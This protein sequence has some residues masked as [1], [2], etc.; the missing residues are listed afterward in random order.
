MAVFIVTYNPTRWRWDDRQ[1]WE[2]RTASGRTIKGRWS[3]GSRT[4]GITPEQDRVFLLRQGPGPRGIMGSGTFLSAAYTDEHWDEDRPGDLANYADILWES[5]L[6]DDDLLPLAE[7]EAQ[8]PGLPWRQGVRGSGAMVPPP[9][10]AELE[11]LWARHT[12]GG[13]QPGGNGGG[14]RKRGSRQAWQDDPV[15]R[16]AVEDY[17]QSLLEQDY[18]D[19]GWSVEDTR[20]G[21]PFDAMAT[22]G[23]QVRYL[24]AKGTETDGR[25]VLV[26]KAEVE[27]ARKHP[28]ECVL[29]IVSDIRFRSDASLDETSGRLVVTPWE[30]DTG[31]LTATG[32]SWAPPASP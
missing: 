1:K 3:I 13:P 29:G 30:P 17:A 5:V 14:A 31:T 32:Y 24:E 2:R 16:K 20:R 4:R 9:A 11:R 23:R 8:V 7:L 26:T 19:K 18:R 27:W 21:N 22:K 25:S 15:R 6:S 12:G 28:G 10:D